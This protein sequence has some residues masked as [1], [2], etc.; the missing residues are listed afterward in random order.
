MILLKVTRKSKHSAKEYLSH[1]SSLSTEMK[2]TR[3]KNRVKLPI[4]QYSHYCVMS[5]W[6]YDHKILTVLYSDVL[7]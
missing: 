4:M 1:T 6:I 7:P 3:S 5:K 2:K